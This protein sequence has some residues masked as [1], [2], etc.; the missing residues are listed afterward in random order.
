MN[1]EP[2]LAALVSELGGRIGLPSL[3]LDE[4]GACALA[5]DGRAQVNFQYRPER[6]AL[7]LFADLGAPAAGPDVYEALLRGNYFWKSTLG[8]T[9]SLSGD[10][11][12]HVILTLP[13]AWRGMDG[14]RLAT[15]LETFVN[16]MEDWGQVI[17]DAGEAPETQ[18]VPDGL[19]TGSMLRI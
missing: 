4:T 10:E 3:A 5:F 16:T 6:E 8:A 12:A 15:V 1:I 7:W 17:A 11:P 2:A 19:D 18:P 9:L 13:V 14:R